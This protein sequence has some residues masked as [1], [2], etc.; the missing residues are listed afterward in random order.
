MAIPKWRP[1]AWFYYTAMVTGGVLVLARVLSQPEALMSP[2]LYWPLLAIPMLVLHNTFIQLPNCDGRVC[3]SGIFVLHA[4]VVWGPGPAALLATVEAFINAFKQSADRFWRLLFNVAALSMAIFFATLMAEWFIPRSPT[5]GVV[6]LFSRGMLIALIYYTLNMGAV[7]GMLSFVQGGIS[8]TARSALLWSWATYAVAGISSGALGLL[9]GREVVAIIVGAVILFLT[10]KTLKH[11]FGV[12]RMREELLGQLK[13]THHA[14]LKT[15]ATAIEAKDPVTHGHVIRVQKLSEQLAKALGVDSE[16][17]ESVSIAALLHDIGKLAVPEYV[18]YGCNDRDPEEQRKF[19]SHALLGA[20]I[21]E[22][23]LVGDD[24]KSFV[25]HHHER[26]DGQGYPHS[27][28]GTEIPYGARIVA[29]ANLYDKLRHP[30]TGEEKPVDEALEALQAESGK[31]LDPDI[32]TCFCRMITER[33]AQGTCS[34]GKDPESHISLETDLDNLSF[35]EDVHLSHKET[36]TLFTLSRNI[37]STNDLSRILDFLLEAIQ[38][39][40]PFSASRTFLTNRSTHELELVHAKGAPEMDASTWPNQR[41]FTRLRQWLDRGLEYVEQ[42]TPGEEAADSSS[43]SPPIHTIAMFPVVLKGSERGMLLLCHAQPFRYS[44]DDRQIVT[45]MIEHAAASVATAREYQQF[46]IE[47]L[48]DALTG[49]ANGRALRQNG[50][51]MIAA[52]TE[53]NRTGCVVMID[54]N[55][56]KQVNDTLGHHEG[57]RLLVNIARLLKEHFRGDDLVARNGGDEF[58]VILVGMD[59]DVLHRRLS[60]LHDEA[61]QLWP[62]DLPPGAAG[63]SCGCAWFPD[64]GAALPDLMKKADARMYEDKRAKK[65]GR[66]AISIG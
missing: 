20:E 26:Y 60:R 49:L 5:E 55:G 21:L 50:P 31:S 30:R 36:R 54:L 25:K 44:E 38:E 16:M 41:W 53:A 65:A 37:R 3:P 17:L 10:V 12:L 1:E 59:R 24:V 32:V 28:A 27:L 13:A 63:I 29:V 2:N 35:M 56:F 47:S 39:F 64:D 48:T 52:A 66:E 34:E 57:D 14:T 45:R 15:L 22:H 58:V 8:S 62:G 4:A 42:R 61:R 46:Q 43:G 23:S 33:R 7:L 40:V 11:Y 6:S 18:L 9:R 19:R 51:G